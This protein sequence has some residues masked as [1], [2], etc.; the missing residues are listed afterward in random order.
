MKTGKPNPDEYAP[1]YETYIS[2]VHTDDPIRELRGDE[3]VLLRF[4]AP[5][6]KKQLKYRYATGK[7][8]IREIL[9]HM[10]DAERIFCYRAL[11][12]A[13][14]DMTELPGFDEKAY[15]AENRAD[16]RKLKSLLAEY[17]AVRAASI[18]LFRNFNEEEL[19]RSGIANGKPMS[20][21]ALLFVIIG[22]QRHHLA[23]INERYL[24]PEYKP[25]SGN[26]N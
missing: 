1:Y 23:V 17:K 4:F 13:R 18:E 21:R 5:L 22:H 19:M 6:K 3:K 25:A 2:K 15:A 20:V 26:G 8:N 9:G 10:I 12:F 24:N 11:R 7:W 14:N 16:I